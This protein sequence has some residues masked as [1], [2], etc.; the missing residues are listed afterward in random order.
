M[1][2]NYKEYHPKW[3][4]ISRLIRFKRAKN[5]CEWCG[6]ENYK[7]NPRTGSKV[8]LTVAHVDRDKNNN[9]FSNLAALCQ[10]CHLNHDKWQHV[11]NRKYGRNWKK[12]Q[13]SINFKNP[14]R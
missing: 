8:I 5:V 3:S 11:I 6:A 13:L 1:P 12:N 9:R 10:Q 14:E 4:L 7:S 2:I